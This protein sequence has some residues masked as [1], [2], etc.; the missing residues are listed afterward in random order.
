M[1]CVVAVGL[2]FLRAIDVVEADTF[3]AV[4]EE[5]VDGCPRDRGPT[6]RAGRHSIRLTNL[7]NDAFR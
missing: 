7:L 1:L 5:N 3:S 4:V 2:A 6:H